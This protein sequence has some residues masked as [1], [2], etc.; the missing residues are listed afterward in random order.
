MLHPQAGEVIA[1]GG[2]CRKVG[3][4]VRGRE[5]H[6][7]AVVIYFYRASTQVTFLLRA[8]LKSEENEFLKN[9]ISQFESEVN[10]NE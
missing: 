2:G 3:W 7:G 10:T 6:D 1:D 9:G 5:T 8:F 4:R